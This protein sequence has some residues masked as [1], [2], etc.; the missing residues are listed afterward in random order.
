MREHGPVVRQPGLDGVTPIWFVTRYEDVNA[1]LLDHERFVRDPSLALTA[2]ELAARA[3]VDERPAGEPHAQPGRGRPSPSPQARHEGVHA[4]QGG[5]PPAAHP[6][7]RRRADRPRRARPGDGPG[8]GIRLPAVDHRD[9]GAARRPCGG[10]RPLPDVV[11]G[12]D[13]AE[14]RAGCDRAVHG[15]DCGV[16]GVPRRPLRDA[17]RGAARRPRGPHSGG[18]RGGDAQRTRAVRHRQTATRVASPI[19]TSSTSGARTPGISPSDAAP[20][21]ASARPSR[22]SRA[23]SPSRLFCAAF[24]ASGSRSRWKSSPTV[25]RP[26]FRSLVALPVAWDQPAG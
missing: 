20:T 8:R 24:Q 23:S 21:T 11:G 19:R 12:G 25:R 14:R 22:D 7:D 10:S 13:H 18:D 4:M 1:V 9:R 6:G 5:G 17:A 2:E 16:H 3:G 15:A 26:S